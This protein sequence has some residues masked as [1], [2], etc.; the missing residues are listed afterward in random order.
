MPSFS[1]QTLTILSSSRLYSLLGKGHLYRSNIWL[2][3]RGGKGL[4]GTLTVL[5]R[6]VLYFAVLYCTVLYCSMLYCTLLYCVLYCV[7]YCA[8]LCCT[9][10]YY[11]MLYYTSLILAL[12]LASGTPPFTKRRLKD[13]I[14]NLTTSPLSSLIPPPPPFRSPQVLKALV[15][16]TPST[17]CCARCS[18]RRGSSCSHLQN[19]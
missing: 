6:T 4:R 8:A 2:G 17:M 12:F 1:L 11:T 10:L 18:D 16:K 13:L 7:L 14:L 3:G 15:I 19:A 9:V 5:Y